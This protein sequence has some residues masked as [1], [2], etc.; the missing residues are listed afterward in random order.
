MLRQER[1][2]GNRPLSLGAGPVYAR[3]AG[4]GIVDQLRA[5]DPDRPVG[6]VDGP[7]LTGAG[8]RIVQR[9]QR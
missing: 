6:V 8:Y 7:S 2:F 9:P 5:A 3:D 4:P 1:T